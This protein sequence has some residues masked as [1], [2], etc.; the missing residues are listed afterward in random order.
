[1]DRRKWRSSKEGY[2]YWFNVENN[3]LYYA[4]EVKY[5][6]KKFNKNSKP[7]DEDVFT[8][9]PSKANNYLKTVLSVNIKTNTITLS[10]EL[11]D[12]LVVESGD[13]VNISI[14]RRYATYIVK[15]SKSKSKSK[16]EY[17]INKNKIKNRELAML[18]K[19]VFELE[20]DT[21]EFKGE[22][23]KHQRG[24]VKNEFLN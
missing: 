21:T 19:V 10:K 12:E 6:K 11:M 24:Y 5:I 16:P 4:K 15:K 17:L 9:K 3:G 22:I 13:Y 8:I 2:L 20:N 1:M 18:F 7:H 23:K 14:N